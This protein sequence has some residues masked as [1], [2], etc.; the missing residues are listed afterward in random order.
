LFKGT[1]I[2]KENGKE[3]GRSYNI[4]TT[5][6]R[7][8]LL[9]Y[10][11]GVKSTWAANLA[12][13]AIPG[14]PTA[15]DLELNFETG[16]YPITLRTYQ[17]ATDSTP[18]LIVVR[19]T[20]PS[21]LYANIYEV[22]VYPT[23]TTSGLNI[24]DN[25]IFTDFS[26]LSNWVTSDGYTEIAG[27]MPQAEQSP[28][29]GNY[30]VSLGP[31][32]TFYNSSVAFDIDLYN[33]IDL[34]QIL[35]HN[36]LQGNLAVTM[37]DAAGYQAVFNYSLSDN[38]DYQILSASFPTTIKDPSGNIINISSEFLKTIKT[39]QFV[40]DSTCSVTLDCLK[41]SANEQIG[42]SDYL[43]SKSSLSTPIAKTY[44][45]PLDIEY[46]IELL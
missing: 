18:D 34:L 11:A 40:T 6:G 16:R 38:P 13:G 32:T 21:T 1:Y 33:S 45:V 5:N 25:K 23:D 43:I 42:T 41:A 29:I 3:I 31:N 22:G 4:I 15:D 12:I 9:Q 36:T 19:A 8:V 2:Y 27:F 26:D 35:A 10:L 46:Y 14:T 44:G 37:I 28:R 20:L 24:V 30:A 39:I 17:A 7:K